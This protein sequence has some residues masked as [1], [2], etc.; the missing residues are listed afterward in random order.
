MKTYFNHSIQSFS[1][2]WKKNSIFLIFTVLFLGIVYF[3]SQLSS[4]SA[5][6][7]IQEEARL[8]ITGQVFDQ[9]GI[10][11]SEVEITALQPG[12]EEPLDQTESLENGVWSVTVPIESL[13]ALEIE[14]VRD[15]FKTQTLI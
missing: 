14:F 2:N 3:L 4:V 12:M 10:P 8:I 9:Q 13:E 6:S 5:S 15:H 7:L 11:I 1:S